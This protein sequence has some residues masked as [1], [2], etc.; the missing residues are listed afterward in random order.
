MRGGSLGVLVAWWVLGGH[1]CA[2]GV[3]AVVDMAG[4]AMVGTVVDMVMRAMLG[5][6]VGEVEGPG[7]GDNIMGTMMGNSRGAV[8]GTIAGEL[9][10]HIARKPVAIEWA[11][12]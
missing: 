12:D 3:G 2:C 9:V 5:T 11:T 10:V 8:V 6:V 1:S 7:E 4:D